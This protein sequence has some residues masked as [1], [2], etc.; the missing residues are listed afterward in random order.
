MNITERIEGVMKTKEQI[1]KLEDQVRV[2]ERELKT[3]IINSGEVDFL[4][5]DYAKL[6]RCYSVTPL[7]YR[8]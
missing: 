6:C 7:R 8:K 3:A 4:S 1:I 2:M 5:I